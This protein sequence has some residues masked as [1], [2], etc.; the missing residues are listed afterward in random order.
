MK[1]VGWLFIS[2]T[3]GALGPKC[4]VAELYTAIVDLE[5]LLKT[6][7]VLMETLKN[8][9]KQQETKLELLKKLVTAV[10]LAIF[11][12]NLLKTKFFTNNF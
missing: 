12:T 9:I 4:T 6:E 2:L 10:D 7:L 11:D 5:A 1:F 8:F 3:L